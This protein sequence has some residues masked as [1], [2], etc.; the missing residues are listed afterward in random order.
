MNTTI[1]KDSKEL[2][3]LQKELK[4]QKDR[5]EKIKNSM[6]TSS[7]AMKE[8]FPQMYLLVYKRDIRRFIMKFAIVFLVAACLFLAIMEML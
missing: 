8:Q 1:M 3:I 2:D 7:D 4:N 6:N 5:I